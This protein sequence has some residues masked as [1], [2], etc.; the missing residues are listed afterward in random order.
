[1]NIKIESPDPLSNVISFERKK[2]EPSLAVKRTNVGPECR[3]IAVFVDPEMRVVTCQN[4][5]AALDPF[6]VVLEMAHKERRWLYD[7]EEWEAMR[8]SRLSDRY[9][10]EWQKQN[11]EISEPPQVLE[12][13]EIWDVF[14]AVLGDK[15]CAMYK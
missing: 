3:H 14:H 1:M 9:D 10:E 4:C 7:L 13:R 5:R 6:Q 12:L 8:D 11:A 2:R 15:F